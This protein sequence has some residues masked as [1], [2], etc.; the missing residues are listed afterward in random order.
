[1]YTIIS[2]LTNQVSPYSWFAFA[3]LC[4][5]RAA[6]QSQSIELDFVPFFLGAAR[7]GVGNPFQY[8]PDIKAKYGNHDLERCASILGLNVKRPTNFPI[9]SLFVRFDPN[10][11]ER[12]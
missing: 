6:L 8:Q 4:N 9:S 3:Y 7:D 2:N 5:I 10:S 11:Q 1:M 12:C